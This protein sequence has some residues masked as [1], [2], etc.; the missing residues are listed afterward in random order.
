MVLGYCVTVGSFTLKV[1]QIQKCVA[2]SSVDG[3]SLSSH[4]LEFSC[5]AGSLVYHVLN[6]YPVSTYAENIS[7]LAQNVALIVLL[8][9]VVN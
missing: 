5:Y 7:L 6:K 4:Y 9:S 1:P 2:S 3:I 8:W